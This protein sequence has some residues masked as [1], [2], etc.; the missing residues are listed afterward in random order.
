MRARASSSPRRRCRSSSACAIILSLVGQCALLPHQRRHGRPVRRRLVP[1]ARH[2]RHPD[3]RGRHAR[4]QRRSPCWSRRRSASAPRSTCPSTRRPRVRKMLKPI[5]EILAAIPSVVLGFFALTWISPNLVQPLCRTRRF[6]MAVGRHRGRH[7]DHAARRIDQRGRHARRARLPARGLVRP[8]ARKRTTSLRVVV[9]GRGLGH[10]GGA[11]ARRL[12]RHRRDDDR[13]DRRRRHRRLAVPAQSVR[14]G[15]DDDGRHDGARH[16]LRQVR[17]A[18]LTFASL[19]FVG[20]LL[21][22]ITL[23]AQPHQRRVRPPRAASVLMATSAQ[24]IATREAVERRL[25]SGGGDVARPRSAGRPAALAADRARRAGRAA[26]ATSYPH[27]CPSSQ[28]D[29]VDFLTSPLSSRPA[30]A[31]IAQGISAR[32]C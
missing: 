6:N 11:P 32:C 1:A 26:W 3:H 14:A 13:L 22:L 7:P 10:R 12:A 29:R 15:P 5:L 4:H 31:G 9:P 23:V 2:V 25:R 30:R 18:E 27:R 8:R 21:F 16:R 19:F 24:A 20:L 28:S 17:G